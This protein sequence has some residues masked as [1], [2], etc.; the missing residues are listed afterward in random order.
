MPAAAIY[1]LT[2]AVVYTVTVIAIN[3]V[4]NSPPSAVVRVTPK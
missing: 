1:G 3:V 4:G 2:K